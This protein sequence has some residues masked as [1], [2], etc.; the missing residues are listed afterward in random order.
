LLKIVIL[1]L[2]V[3]FQPLFDSEGVVYESEWRFL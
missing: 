1:L 2:N 3:M